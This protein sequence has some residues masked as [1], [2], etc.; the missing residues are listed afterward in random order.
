[1]FLVSSI[2]VVKNPGQ[3]RYIRSWYHREITI[4]FISILFYFLLIAVI[5]ISYALI[6]SK[7]F[8]DFSQKFVVYIS[9]ISG[10]C[11]YNSMIEYTKNLYSAS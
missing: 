11:L 7:K 1:M 5:S 4:S 2:R 6:F 3:V 9:L 8:S 10:L